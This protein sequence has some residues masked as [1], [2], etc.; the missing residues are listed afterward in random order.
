MEFALEKTNQVTTLHIGDISIMSDSQ[1][2]YLEHLPLLNQDLQGHVLITGLGLGFVNRFL[3]NRPKIQ[4]VTIVE[5]YEEVIDMIWDSCP[6]DERFN[7]VHADAESWDP[8]M[9]YDFTWID[10]WIGE[11]IAPPDKWIEQMKEKYLPFSR[12][13]LFWYPD[14]NRPHLFEPC[15]ES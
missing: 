3:I 9:V 11:A 12:Q 5:K 13:L 7:I 6:K 2:E 1:Q 4:S 10:S 8:P 14:E 15:H